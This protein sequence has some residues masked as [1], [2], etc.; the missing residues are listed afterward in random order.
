[1]LNFEVRKKE[2]EHY[3]SK[4]INMHDLH[5]ATYVIHATQSFKYRS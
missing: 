5:Y 2:N 4:V 3:T 1:M